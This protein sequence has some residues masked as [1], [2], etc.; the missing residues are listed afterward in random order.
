M[1]IRPNRMLANRRSEYSVIKRGWK[2]LVYFKGE[3]DLHNFVISRIIR[4][5]RDSETK[6][7]YEESAFSTQA[8]RAA[9]GALQ[10]PRRKAIQFDRV[11][12]ELSGSKMVQMKKSSKGVY[13]KQANQGLDCLDRNK[14][15]VGWCSVVR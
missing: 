5:C 14:G 8:Q 10:R 12:R 13:E 9:A 4:H 3:S 7:W 2:Y 15:L 11:N 1:W 6:T